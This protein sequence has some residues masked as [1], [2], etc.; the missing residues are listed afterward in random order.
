MIRDS[1]AAYH[2]V[3][4][5][6]YFTMM[7][8]LSMFLMHPV[9][10]LISFFS[11]FIYAVILGGKKSVR[12]NILYLIPMMLVIAVINPLFNH[13]GVTI[14]FYLKNGN[15]ITMES[16]FFGI[17][18]A[19]MIITVMSWFYCY[20]KVMES[21]KFIYLFGNIMPALSLIFSMVLRFVPRYTNQIKRIAHAQ[22]GLGNDI[23]QGSILKRARTGIKILSI[24]TT[25]ALEN[26]I[27]TSDSMKSRGYGLKK[28]T[29]F[30]I[31]VFTSRDKKVLLIIIFLAVVIAL[32]GYGGY[33]SFTY[34]PYIK[35]KDFDGRAV[36]TFVS[37]SL[38]CLTPSVINIYEEMKWRYYIQKI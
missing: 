18:S 38:L 29:A 22:K 37:Y 14:L 26:Q 21:D 25:W 8:V 10:Q 32:G 16:I 27:E 30:S 31:Y 11:A 5:F 19:L 20:N 33:M 6:V 3:I 4:N 36:I 17:S 2:P 28:R 12:F 34:Y 23:A 1:F 9:L 13:E 24:M 15:P 7:M 35:Y